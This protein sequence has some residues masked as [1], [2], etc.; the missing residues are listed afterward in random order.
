VLSIGLLA[1]TAVL[2]D[3]PYLEVRRIAERV[4][5]RDLAAQVA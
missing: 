3:S 1:A 4:A 5:D 2:L